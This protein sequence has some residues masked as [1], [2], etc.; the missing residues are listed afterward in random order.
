[1]G[2]NN[3][4]LLLDNLPLSVELHI[5]SSFILVVLGAEVVLVLEMHKRR[6]PESGIPA[7]RVCLVGIRT[8]VALNGVELI[9]LLLYGA[10]SDVFVV[11][12]GMSLVIVYAGCIALFARLRP[13]ARARPILFRVILPL[14]IMVNIVLLAIHLVQLFSA[15][16]I[17]IL[18]DFV[19]IGGASPIIVAPCILALFLHTQGDRTIKPYYLFMVAS[20]AMLGLGG[21]F[22]LLPIEDGLA[23]IDVDREVTAFLSMVFSVAGAAIFLGAVYVMPYVEDIY[24]R[25]A[26]LAV[27]VINTETGSVLFKR[28][29]QD[30]E[31]MAISVM[32]TNVQDSALIGGLSGID[33]LVREMI[34]DTGGRLELLDKEGLKFMMSWYKQYLFVAVSR[35]NLP[36]IKVKLAE[37]KNHCITHF[38]DAMKDN[39]IT[40]SSM[41]DLD[42]AAECIFKG[43]GLT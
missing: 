1:M 11:I 22:Y 15:R 35:L 37:F 23:R 6:N 16:S 17:V 39:T 14:E 34:R 25:K 24:W 26:V 9:C 33:D 29:F 28:N 32:Q 8:L 3:M 21:A 12:Y 4:L 36:V 7:I 5:I 20:L 30:G 38:G 31:D 27:Y 40:A 42:R 2:S 10:N 43:R 13:F 41:A 18:P 19:S